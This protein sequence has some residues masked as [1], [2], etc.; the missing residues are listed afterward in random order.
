MR[1]N[2]ERIKGGQL[3]FIFVLV[4]ILSMICT[5]A[6]A[7]NRVLGADLSLLPAYEDAGT[8]YYPMNGAAAIPDV[9]SY[10]KDEAGMNAVRVRLFVG[11]DGSD[12]SVCQN[13]E[14]VKKLGKRIKDAGMKF[15]LDFHYSDT[16][17]DPQSQIIPASWYDLEEIK[18]LDNLN[19]GTVWEL[20]N[21]YTTACLKE[22]VNYGAYPDY[23]QIGNEISYGM[24]WRKE[25]DKVYPKL[26][27][28]DRDWQWKRLAQIL[29]AGSRAVRAETPKAKIIIHTERIAESDAT[30]NF[31]TYMDNL[32]V[33]YD[34]IGLSYYPFYHG[35]L[36]QLKKTLDDLQT[37]FPTRE[38]HIVET[39]YFYSN[40][41]ADATY[42][43]TGTWPA[44]AAGQQAYVD[45]LVSELWKHPNVTGLYWWFAEENGNG[46]RTKNVLNTWLNRGLWNNSTHRALPAL[47]KMKAFMTDPTT[48]II[49]PKQTVKKNEDLFDLSGRK[50]KKGGKGIYV[51]G[52][53][54][55][56]IR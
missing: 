6:P 10:V 15:L 37:A 31:Y 54:S 38:V 11:P 52:G 9:I 33:D 55:F 49:Q 16:W 21:N 2:I 13:L 30:V 43:L 44:T 17:A 12:P 18:D 53:V 48:S 8:E 19:D 42:D 36:V 25:Y 40:Y 56:I 23:V 46:S 51:G 45:D 22:L 14:Y 26:A 41:A 34:I 29:D 20:V 7:Q 24:L 32:N 50:V 27:Q 3:P 4:F 1:N 28:S 47:Y 39:A 35:D 5:K